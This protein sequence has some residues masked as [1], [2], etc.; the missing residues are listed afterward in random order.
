MPSA[1]KL[2]V[3]TSW[4]DG[5]KTDLKLA[6]LLEKYGVKGTF[7][8]PNSIDDALSGKE[9]IALDKQFEAGAHSVNQPD[10]TRV[11][12][13]EATRQIKESKAYLEDLLGHLVPMFCYPYGRYN[14]AIKRLVKDTGFM[15]ARTCD[16]GGLNPPGDPYQWH[17]TT[18]ASNS[19]PLMALKICRRFRL[20]KAS[21]LLDWEERAK[22]VF[23]L[24]L[25]RGGVYHIYGHSAELEKDRAWDKT[26]RVLKYI[27]N[28]EKVRYL[29]N[30]EVFQASSK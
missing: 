24:A 3:T 4:D 9:I 27:A 2:I 19:S 8:V 14:E 22:S 11:T 1:E 15:A 28:R 21:G 6:G 5:T 23:N 18:F 7:Y 10:L 25:E 20:W 16:P 29:T 26:E 30:G 13:P 12:M 17:I